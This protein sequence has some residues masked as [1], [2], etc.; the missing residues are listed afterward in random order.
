MLSYY[1]HI[2][3]PPIIIQL[4]VR[5]KNWVY[6]FR[7]LNCTVYKDLCDNELSACSNIA[8]WWF[9]LINN[10]CSFLLCVLL[11][12]YQLYCLW[13]RGL[14]MLAK[15]IVAM[16]ETSTRGKKLIRIRNARNNFTPLVL[17]FG[18][19]AGIWWVWGG[20]TSQH[21]GKSTTPSPW[22]DLGDVQ[23]LLELLSMG[24]IYSAQCL[25]LLLWPC[26]V[27]LPPCGPS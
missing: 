10:R 14:Q 13:S 19:S 4:M 27:S 12:I 1:R 23:M 24:D 11:G 3:H 25:S 26:F 2:F 5:L 7:E 15:E 16:M 17:S 22:D 18:V 21:V 8:F 20:F 6:C 9:I